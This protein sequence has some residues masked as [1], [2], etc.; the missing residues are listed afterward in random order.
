VLT[1]NL[2]GT[3][4]LFIRADFGLLKLDILLVAGLLGAV[5]ADH[6]SGPQ[7]HAVGSRTRKISAVSWAYACPGV[8][9]RT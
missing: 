5:T 2:K 1:V 3:I 4:W 6:A 7:S 9:S 8:A